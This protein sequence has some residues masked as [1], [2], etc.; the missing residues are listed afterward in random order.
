M[1][2]YEGITNEDSSVQYLV[3]PQDPSSLFISELTSITN[4]IV[5]HALLL[6]NA[7]NNVLYFN[8]Y[9]GHCEW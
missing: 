6:P 7:M 4:E 8:R 2:N 3:N 9:I 1:L 5:K